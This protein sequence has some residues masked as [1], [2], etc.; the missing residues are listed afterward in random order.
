ME[1]E[2]TGR[3]QLSWQTDSKPGWMDLSDDDINNRR[4]IIDQEEWNAWMK[5][6]IAQGIES[7]VVDIPSSTE[8][9]VTASN[10]SDTIRQDTDSI[11]AESL[12]ENA[13]GLQTTIEE[14]TSD[15]VS[16]ASDTEDELQS[17]AGESTETDTAENT[18][19][20]KVLYVLFILILIQVIILSVIII[21]RKRNAASP[22]T[23]R[24]ELH[25]ERV[26]AGSVGML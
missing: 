13:S 25:C 1:S 17:I 18:T 24:P 7:G 4:I 16:A 14:S 15:N 21:Q 8:S 10:V 20:S 11:K 12:E 23:R 5:Q 26:S 6:N 9:D 3:E 22:D 19:V 2:L